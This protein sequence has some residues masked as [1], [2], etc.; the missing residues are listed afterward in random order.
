VDKG[1][2]KELNQA[3]F[4]MENEIKLLD[5]PVSNNLM[6][7][8]NKVKSTIA[9]V[10]FFNDDGEAVDVRTDLKCPY[11]ESKVYDNRAK[12]RDPNDSYYRTKK[13]DFGCSNFEPESCS[14][15]TWKNND[16]DSGV[17]FSASWW[18]TSTPI[19]QEW[20]I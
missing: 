20:N 2:K 18:L 10:F 12:K 16:L 6:N 4:D 5:S 9:G 7:Y 15:G 11:C 13:P 1:S 8:L 14:G 19:P 17:W 3:L